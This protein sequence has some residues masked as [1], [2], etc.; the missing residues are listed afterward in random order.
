MECM[1]YECTIG[2]HFENPLARLR[3]WLTVNNL[4]MNTECYIE[5][6]VSFL[7]GG[8]GSKARLEESHQKAV[9]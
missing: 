8:H 9:R 4:L 5:N 3:E 1:K 2:H 6:C 7:G